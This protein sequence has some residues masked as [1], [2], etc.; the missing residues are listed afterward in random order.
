[1]PACTRTSW[2]GF[3]MCTGI[4]ALTF[5]VVNLPWMVGESGNCFGVGGRRL[6]WWR[7]WW[8]LWVMPAHTRLQ[9]HRHRLSWCHTPNI[10]LCISIYVHKVHILE[11]LRCIIICGVTWGLP[12]V[13]YENMRRALLPVVVLLPIYNVLYFVVPSCIITVAL[14]RWQI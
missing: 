12:G 1:M 5:I 6:W 9:T 14:F 3:D 13:R 11:N 2:K 8:G 4:V 10:P 7:R